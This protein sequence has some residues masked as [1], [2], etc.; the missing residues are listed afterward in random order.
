MAHHAHLLV[1]LVATLHNY[2]L[3]RGQRRCCGCAERRA[4]FHGG[5]PGRSQHIFG[6]RDI[7]ARHPA[8]RAAVYVQRGARFDNLRLDC[9]PHVRSPLGCTGINCGMCERASMQWCSYHLG[10]CRSCWHMALKVTGNSAS[11]ARCTCQK[12]MPASA[13]TT[14]TCPLLRQRCRHDTGSVFQ[15]MEP[16][17]ETQNVNRTH[18]ASCPRASSCGGTTATRTAGTW[19]WTSAACAASRCWAW[20]TSRWTV[21][22]CCWARRSGWRRR[23]SRSVRCSSCGAA[24]CGRCT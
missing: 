24:A 18:Q 8:V 5:G 6:Q 4:P 23:T 3:G 12:A 22:G 11:Q 1:C 2:A 10:L 21:R 19:A 15:T 17:N 13:Q 7:G 14:R 9:N 20:A 16:P